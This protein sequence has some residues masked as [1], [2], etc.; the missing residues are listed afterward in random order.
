MPGALGRHCDESTM[1]TSL[2]SWTS[3]PNW[4]PPSW[5]TPPT[6]S[7]GTPRRSASTYPRPT[8][9][10]SLPGGSPTTRLG[11]GASPAATS[12]LRKRPPCS[13]GSRLPDAGRSTWWRPGPTTS[14][15]YGRTTSCSRSAPTHTASSPSSSSPTCA[16]PSRSGASRTY[17]RWWNRP[18]S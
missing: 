1:I 14:S 17:R 7:P 3:R 4:T 15:S 16:C 11:S 10:A 9:R 2:K 8:C 6:R 5:V 18:A 12:C 13:T